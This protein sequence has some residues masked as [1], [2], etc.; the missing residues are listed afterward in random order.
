[1]TFWTFI[2]QFVLAWIAIG[3][4]LYVP[5]RL[6]VRLL[7]I[8]LEQLEHLVASL[9]GGTGLFVLLY[10]AFATMQQPWIIWPVV[11]IAIVWEVIASVQ[12]WKKAKQFIADPGAPLPILLKT[13][14]PLGVLMLIGMLV[15]GRY[16]LFTGWLGESGFSLLAFHAHD[17]PWHLYNI[18]QLTKIFPPEMPG[19]AGQTLHNYHM[20]SDLLWGGLLRFVP[21]HP[22]HCYFRIAPLFYSGLLTLTAFVAARHWSGKDMVGYLAA[23][24][25]VLFSNFGYLIPLFFGAENYPIWESIFWIQSPH[26]MIFNPGVSSSFSFMFFG[27]WALLQWVRREREWGFLI[28]LALLWGVLP[29]FKVYPGVLALCGLFVSGA[30]LFIA[31]RNY[32]MWIALAAVL[33]I[34]LLV[35]LPGNSGASSMLK[36]LPGFNLGAMLVAPDRLGWMT[37]EE[38]KLLFVAKPWLVAL[39]MAGLSLLFVIGN[40]GVR[41]IGLVP[42]VRSLFHLKRVEPGIL[43]ITVVVAGAFMAP[44]LFVQHG[45]SWNVVQFSYYAV[46][47]SALPAADQLWKWIEQHNVRVQGAVIA[48]LVLLGIPATIQSLVVVQW[49]YKTDAAVM[50]GFT[51]LQDNAKQQDVILRPLPDALMTEAGYA[52]WKRSQSRGRMTNMDDWQKEAELMAQAAEHE[53]TSTTITAVVEKEEQTEISVLTEQ[54]ITAVTNTETAEAEKVLAG[55]DVM[56]ALERTD[57]AIVAGL[58]LRNTYLEDTVSSQVLDFPVEKR[59]LAVR[60][61]YS[62][63]DVVEAREFLEK[64][65]ITYVILLAEQVLPFDAKGASLKQVF[66]NESILIYKYIYPGGW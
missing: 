22:W 53:A 58:V 1:M 25:T 45:I 10:Y 17:A 37:S 14:W 59:L 32:K 36:F 24:M 15:Q 54:T 6:L 57:T 18:S 23:V 16:T 33:P 42:M 51:W 61:F 30:V 20:F 62:K 13:F 64:E 19:F 65:K 34:F 63:A 28:L 56:P 26:A 12:D 43:F 46:L 49:K 31:Q 9:M 21:I 39:I 44:I 29:G 35:F 7:R 47:L 5:G 60:Y 55:N 27:F 41:V 48:L 3:A 52:E 11:F 2:L 50:Q 66:K 8:E 4:V 40:L 38:L